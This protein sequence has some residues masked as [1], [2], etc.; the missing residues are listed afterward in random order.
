MTSWIVFRH[1]VHSV[2]EVFNSPSASAH[3]PTAGLTC[4]YLQ[5]EVINHSTGLV[6]SLPRLGLLQ[7]IS[8]YPNTYKGTGFHNYISFSKL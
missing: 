1:A 2:N 4:T 7:Q 5:T 6:V 8:G 3:Q